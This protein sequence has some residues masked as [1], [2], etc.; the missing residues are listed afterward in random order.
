MTASRQKAGGMILYMEAF[1]EERSD[2]LISIETDNYHIKGKKGNWLSIDSIVVEGREFFLME[3]KEYG[4]DAA[5]VVLDSSGAVVEEVNYH[6]FDEYAKQ[7]IREWLHPLETVQTEARTKAE[8]TPLENWQKYMENGEYLRSAEISEEQNYNMID[9]RQNNGAPGEKAGRISV[10]ARLRQKQSKLEKR[11]EEPS[12][13]IT[14][15]ED[16]DRRS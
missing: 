2:T 5:Y 11:R 12:P 9:G 6:G 4:P 13:Q 15:S 16:V 3:H 1:M 8:E 10:L 14:A 7:Q